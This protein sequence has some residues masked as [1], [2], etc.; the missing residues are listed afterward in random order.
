MPLGASWS[1]LGP[2]ECHIV[3]LGPIV[4]RLGAVLDRL[5]SSEMDEIGRFSSRLGEHLSFWKKKT[6]TLKNRH[7][8]NR[9]EHVEIIE[10]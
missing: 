10:K 7:G 6:G 5:R 8:S 9:H 1:P 2:S 3:R 4:R